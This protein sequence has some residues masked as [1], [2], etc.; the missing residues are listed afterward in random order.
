MT[1]GFYKFIAKKTLFILSKISLVLVPLSIFSHYIRESIGN[2]TWINFDYSIPV[3]Y[4][5]SFILAIGFL[6]AML[7]IIINIFLIIRILVIYVSKTK[8]RL[9]TEFKEQ[10]K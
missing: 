10:Q 1:L 7:G 8:K 3:Q 5:L 6:C 9:I 2:N 4:F